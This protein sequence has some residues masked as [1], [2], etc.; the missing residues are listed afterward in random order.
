[1]EEEAYFA[2]CADYL[3]RQIEHEGPDNVAAFIAEPIM[4]AHGV[5]TA[6]DGVFRTGPRDL[7]PL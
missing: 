6:S 4:Q 5:Q 1:M 3:E 2:F 7:R